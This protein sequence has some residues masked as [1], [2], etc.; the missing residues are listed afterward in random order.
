MV[1]VGNDGK[2]ANEFLV[3]A[4]SGLRHFF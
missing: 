3:D 1:D 4:H 2:V